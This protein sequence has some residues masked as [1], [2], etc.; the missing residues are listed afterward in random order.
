MEI[1]IIIVGIGFIAIGFFVKKNPDYIAGYN[2][3]PEAAK[4]NVDI[5]GLSSFIKN[6]LIIMGLAIIIE[7]H[8]LK[9]VGFPLIANFVIKQSMLVGVA[10][11]IIYAQKYDHNRS[12]KS[13]LIT[14]FVGLLIIFG[15]EY[16]MWR[17]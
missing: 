17:Y 11:I 14:I 5:D 2:T 12:K 13:K 15:V 6:A 4:K 9:W 8:I 7:F 10:I 16:L 3:M 1:G